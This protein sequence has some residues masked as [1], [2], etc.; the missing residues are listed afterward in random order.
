MSA[1][2]DV[3]GQQGMNLFTKGSV[4]MDYG[5]IFWPE[6]LKLKCHNDE[7]VF[8]QHTA[9]VSQDINW[10][11]SSHVD[12]CDGLSADSHSDGT[13]SLQRKWV[14]LNFSNLFQWRNKLI[15]ILDGL[16]VKFQYIF[17]LYE[18]FLLFWDYWNYL[19]LFKSKKVICLCFC[20]GAKWVKVKWKY[21]WK[22]TLCLQCHLPNWHLGHSAAFALES[23]SHNALR[24]WKHPVHH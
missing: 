9:F 8:L 2:F 18:L 21:L 14:M 22:D 5:L 10:W 11:N 6:C 19:H 13:H 23:F 20:V 12:Y 15:C 17:I 1:D 3:R 24:R 7:F 16:R 4:I